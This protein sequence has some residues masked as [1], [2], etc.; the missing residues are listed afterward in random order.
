LKDKQT[1]YNQAIDEAFAQA[2]YNSHIID[3]S[4]MSVPQ[5]HEAMGEVRRRLALEPTILNENGSITAMLR[6]HSGEVAEGYDHVRKA[7]GSFKVRSDG[8]RIRRP[9]MVK[10]E[11]NLDE[12]KYIENHVNKTW[13]LEPGAGNSSITMK[14]QAGQAGHHFND[15]VAQNPA[16]SAQSN[17]IKDNWD[18]FNQTGRVPMD[19]FQKHWK[20]AEA[21]QS[22]TNTWSV[23]D[24]DED[25]V[26]VTGS[27][28]GRSIIE[29]GVNYIAKYRNDGTLMVV[30]SDRHDFLEKMP[31]IG[32]VVSEMLPINKVSLSSL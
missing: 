12:A 10:R 4:G 19:K 17:M 13:G 3:Q 11:Q 25:G 32:K 24:F 2:G 28:T 31:I 15:V 14:P 1:S 16:N 5:M 26:W 22:S 6:E 8:K 30:M 21:N 7:D 20:S 27:K 9:K 18:E 29:G 23:L